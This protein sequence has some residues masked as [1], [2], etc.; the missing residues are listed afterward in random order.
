MADLV[1]ISVVVD[2]MILYI[3][4]FGDFMPKFS[5]AVSVS[6]GLPVARIQSHRDAV[7]V[8]SDRTNL[9]GPVSAYVGQLDTLLLVVLCILL[10]SAEAVNE[11]DGNFVR[12]L[13]VDQLNEYDYLP[14][15][16]T[17]T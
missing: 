8:G 13:S 1:V 7:I 11:G 16:P 6:R 3:S 10:I 4:S 9:R 12:R 2:S 17:V 5:F 14:F 15:S